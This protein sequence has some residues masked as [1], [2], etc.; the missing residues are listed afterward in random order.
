MIEPIGTNILFRMIRKKNEGGIEVPDLFSEGTEGIVLQVGDG[1]RDAR[2]NNII[3]DV[4]P[5]DR[6]G[7]DLRMIVPVTWDGPREERY[8]IDNKDILYKYE[9][10]YNDQRF[11]EMSSRDAVH[12]K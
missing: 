3:F 10:D 4:K 6:I 8:I 11:E 1:G 7:F 12:T 5:G 2:K 9:Q